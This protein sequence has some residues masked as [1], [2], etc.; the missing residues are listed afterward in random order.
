M[1]AATAYLYGGKAR[2]NTK[3]AK[4]SINPNNLHSALKV[5][6]GC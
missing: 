4:A 1:K 2:L 3:S 5:E 6:S